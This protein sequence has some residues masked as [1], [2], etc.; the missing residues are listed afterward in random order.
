MTG[1]FTSMI[2]M[3]TSMTGMFTV[4]SLN[5]FLSALE[6]LPLAQE[7]KYSGIVKRFVSYFI[8]KMSVVCA[9]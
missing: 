2:G 5:S 9:R 6:I 7:N 4:A 1:M 3:F 8:M